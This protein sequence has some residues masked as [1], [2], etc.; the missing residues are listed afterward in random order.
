MKKNS[1]LFGLCMLTLFVLTLSP[2]ITNGD[3]TKTKDDWISL[4]DGKS[5]QG[6]VQFL[7]D[8]NADP[9]KTWMI[10]DGVIFCTGEPAGYIRTDKKFSNYQLQLEWRWVETPGNSG[11]L[12]H[13]QDKDEVWPKSIEAQLMHEN[14]GDFWV[15]GGTDFEEHKNADDRRVPKRAK[16]SEKKPGKWNQYDIWCE[17]DSIRIFVNGTLQNEAHKCTVTE[18]YI[19]LQSEGAPIE[20]RNIR[21]R[22]ITPKQ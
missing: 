13:V 10:K 7:P 15:I 3:D 5:L 12:L 20:F 16:S 2:S 4:F 21:L 17:G 19:A 9:A 18:G 11:V 1:Y 8:P 6:W 14:A 22:K